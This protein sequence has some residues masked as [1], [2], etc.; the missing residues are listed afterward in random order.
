MSAARCQCGNPDWPGRCPG[1]AACP[2]ADETPRCRVCGDS[3]RHRQDHDD[4]WICAG[5]HECEDCGTADDIEDRRAV[6]D[7]R[8]EPIWLC[9]SC[10]DGRA[11]DHAERSLS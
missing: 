9:G 4:T 2:C 1:S 3:T 5:C 8:P 7:P 11:Q 6:D 10:T